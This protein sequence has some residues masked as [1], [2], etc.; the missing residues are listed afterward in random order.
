[1]H[2]GGE[3]LKRI[4]LLQMRGIYL[5]QDRVAVYLVRHNDV[6]NVSEST[7][8]IHHMISHVLG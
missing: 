7:N 8:T 4:K 5:L 6:R 3:G 1:M 2:S